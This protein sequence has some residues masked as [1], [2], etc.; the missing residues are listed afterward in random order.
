MSAPPAPTCRACGL[1]VIGGAA[2]DGH[3][4]RCLFQTAFSEAPPVAAAEPWT[5]FSGL[6]LHEEIGRGGMG[7]VYRARQAALGRTVAVKVLLRAHFADPVD[8]ARFA[9]EAKAAASLRHPGIVGVLDFGEHEGTPWFSMEC[10]E[11]VSLD[12][13]AREHPPT[14]RAAAALVSAVGE[15]VAHAHA[16]GLV[17]RDLKPANILM[18]VDG[19]PR[20][21][22]FG[23]A[24]RLRPGAAGTTRTGQGLGSPGYAAPELALAGLSDVRTDVYGLGAVLYHLLTGRPPFD[25]PT[26]ESVLL[27][28]QGSDP[29]PP[30]TFNPSIPADLETVCLTCLAKDPDRRYATAREVVDELGRYLADL[31]ILARPPG[32]LRRLAKWT[33]RHPAVAAAVLGLLLLL[34]GGAAALIVIARQQTLA[35]HR[36]SLVSDSTA[37]LGSRRAGGRTEALAKLRMAWDIRPAA[38]IRNHAA[39]WLALPELSTP[40]TTHAGVAP[41]PGALS[42]DG[43]RHVRVEDGWIV[44]RSALDGTPLARLPGGKPGMLLALDDSGDRLAQC[45]KGERIVT[46]R[47]VADGSTLAT[48]AHPQP[49]GAVAWS[50]QLIATACDNRFIHIWDDTGRLRHRFSG[51]ESPHIRL[52]FRPGGQEL[53]SASDDNHIHL[54]HAARGEELLHLERAHPPYASLGWSPDGK[55]LLAWSHDGRLESYAVDLGTFLD[56]LAPPKDEPH[57]E[58]LG[59]ADLAHDGTLAVV[60]DEEVARVWDFSTGR[61]VAAMPKQPGQWLG[62]R[63]SPLGDRLLTG[64]WTD[65]LSSRALL[66]GP[67]LGP[68][69]VVLDE[70]GHLLRAVGSDGRLAVL[71]NNGTGRFTVVDLGNGAATSV[72]QTNTLATL[73]A[74]DGTWLVTTSYAQPGLTAWSL[75]AGSKLAELCRDEVVMQLLAVGPDRLIAKTAEHLRVIDTAGWAEISKPFRHPQYRGMAVTRD[76]RTLAAA[77]NTDIRLLDATTFTERLRLTPPAHAGWLGECDLSFDGDGSHLL[78][79]TALGCVLRWHLASLQ[80]ELRRLGFHEAQLAPGS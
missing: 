33:R 40:V 34:A 19:R 76:G 3:C 12:V 65:P 16:H 58:N 80:A 22:D 49:V 44:L 72:P 10:V 41:P 55:S 54:W 27:Q 1:P 18:E 31:P 28:L 5:T 21:T 77:T 50:G 14:A 42:G 73:L 20:I 11:G 36:A 17:H 68:P 48:C 53:A 60:V 35:E 46:L 78:V 29:L 6:E 38:P 24:S 7:V 47:S 51:H 61:L 45:G 63:W 13:Q 66:P 67:A 69:S 2:T 26:V 70:T 74:R 57:S 37:L 62:A 75:P 59:S 56:V 30:R 64:G 32:P 39:A 43:R 4:P 71:S 23:I 52:A 8:K 79:H 25:G 15:A 9:Q